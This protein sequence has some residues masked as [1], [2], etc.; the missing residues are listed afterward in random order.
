[1][2]DIRAVRALDPCISKCK[3]IPPGKF[4]IGSTNTFVNSRS[5]IRLF[6]KS[7]PGP[8]AVL[9]GSSKTF[10]NSK[11]AARVKDKVFCGKIINGSFNT[12]IY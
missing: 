6:D 3:K 12:F 7:I 8:G 1:M 10:V 4:L 2:P 9:T 5:Q 11:P